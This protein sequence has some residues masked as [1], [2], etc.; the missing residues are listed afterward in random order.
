MLSRMLMVVALA[1]AVVQATIPYDFQNLDDLARLSQMYEM[2]LIEDQASS[3]EPVPPRNPF[4]PLASVYDV[5]PRSSDDA[6]SLWGEEDDDEGLYNLPLF[7]GAQARDEEHLEHSALQGLHAVAGGTLEAEGQKLVKTDKPLPAYCNPPN[8][9]P[10]GKTEKDNCVE[11]FENSM[12][13]NKNLL[14]KQDCPCDTE[15]MWSC[16]AGQRTVTSKGSGGQAALSQVMSELAELHN[17]NEF[18][19]ENNPYLTT[20]DK[21]DKLVAKK[22]PGLVRRKRAQEKEEDWNPYFEGKRL[23]IAAKK[24]PEI[25]GPVQV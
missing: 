4:E 11:N 9:C 18:S 22:S 16:P 3:F 15:H 20:S 6:Q 5:D 1:V 25:T 2:G 17:A 23:E 8:P 12:D 7:S 19:L 24:S 21:R 14:A 13:N 10:L